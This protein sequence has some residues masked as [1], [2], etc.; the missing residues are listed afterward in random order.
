[1]RSALIGLRDVYK[2]VND[3]TN[4]GPKVSRLRQLHLALDLAVRDAYAACDPHHHWHEVELDHDFYDCGDLGIRFTLSE[5][6]RERLLGWLLELNFRRYAEEKRVPYE[7]VL[8]ET[9]NA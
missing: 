5:P 4:S 1:M 7:H 6:T 9:G 8:R 3:P 2:R